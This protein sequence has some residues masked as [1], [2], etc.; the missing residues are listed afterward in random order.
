MF[1]GTVT[2]HSQWYYDH[3][4]FFFYFFFSQSS[5]CKQIES[6]RGLLLFLPRTLFL[7]FETGVVVWSWKTQ[8]Q[9]RSLLKWASILLTWWN[10][11]QSSVVYW[12]HCGGTSHLF[13][14]ET[15]F[16]YSQCYSFSPPTQT[17]TTTYLHLLANDLNHTHT[18]VQKVQVKSLACYPR[19]LLINPGVLLGTTQGRGWC[20]AD[21]GARAMYHISIQKRPTE[22]V[23]IEP[24]GFYFSY[25]QRER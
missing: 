18:K 16:S 1:I 25:F 9:Q 19:R 10:H 17:A 5:T 24:D 20:L 22:T 3:F 21:I 7:V 15:N 23:Y 2:L 12:S 8:I 6:P 13:P 4:S 14:S 11:I